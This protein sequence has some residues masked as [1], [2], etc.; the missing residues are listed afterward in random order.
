MAYVVDPSGSAGSQLKLF[1]PLQ[2]TYIGFGLAMPADAKIVYALW[3]TQPRF[4]SGGNI[5]GNGT[6]GLLFDQPLPFASQALGG[7]ASTTSQK[8]WFSVR[9]SRMSNADYQLDIRPLVPGGQLPPYFW[10][11][12]FSLTIDPNPSEVW[13]AVD[14][15]LDTHDQQ[16]SYHGQIHLANRQQ[17]SQTSS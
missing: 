11:G 1:A 9:L 13:Q 14:I 8:G 4:D 3:I 2:K 5:V 10:G 7:S 6:F 16:G 15:G 17:S 12:N